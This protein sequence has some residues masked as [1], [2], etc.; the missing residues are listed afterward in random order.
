MMH[1]ILIVFAAMSAILAP[2]AAMSLRKPDPAAASK[3]RPA[4]PATS[5]QPRVAL[6][7][8]LTADRAFAAAARDKPLPQALAAMIDA[9]GLVPVADAKFARGPAQAEAWFANNPLNV[10]STVT[11]A[12]VRGGISR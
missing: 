5:P 11:W 12:P 9:E 6:E 2:A 10:K 1:R 8:L 7:G 4:S 3:P